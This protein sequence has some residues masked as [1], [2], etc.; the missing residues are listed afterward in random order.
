MKKPTLRYWD[1]SVFIAWLTP[2]EDRAQLC[3]GVISAAEAGSIQI[4]T[5]AV[6]LIEVIRLKNS[7]GLD[8]DR[9]GEITDFFQQDYLAIRNVEP[10]LAEQARQLIWTYGLHWK[11]A[12][13]VATALKHGVSRMDSFDEDLIGKSFDGRLTIGK[14]DLPFVEQTRLDIEGDAGTS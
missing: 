14:P 1:S 10:F 9:R 7:K 8:A 12:T 6:T 5:S 4:V 3:K 11:D 2:E 13:H